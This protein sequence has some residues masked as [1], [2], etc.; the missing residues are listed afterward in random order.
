M[1]L[2]F[3]TFVLSMTSVAFSCPLLSGVYVGCKV[4]DQLFENPKTQVIS[5]EIVDGFHTYSI[6]DDELK[7]FSF[8][9]DKVNTI[10][11][12]YDD[13]EGL[14]LVTK[15]QP[16][17]LDNKISLDIVSMQAVRKL[18]STISDED[19]QLTND[20]LSGMGESMKDVYSLDS[21][22]NLIIE[23]FLFEEVVNT[24]TCTAL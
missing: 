16:V 14:N 2:L 17:C 24:T 18:N 9:L 20:L 12:N 7:T 5:L 1:K 6:V 4:S 23:S 19:L 22:G 11:D 8:T 3:F 13:V 15:F 21:D 10:T